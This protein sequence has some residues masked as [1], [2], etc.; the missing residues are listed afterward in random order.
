MNGQSNGESHSRKK[1]RDKFALKLSY[2]HLGTEHRD[3][4]WRSACGV[5]ETILAPPQNGIG[6][7]K[8]YIKFAQVHLKKTHWPV[9]KTVVRPFLH[10]LINSYDTFHQIIYFSWMCM[11]HSWK[12]S[13]SKS[14]TPKGRLSPFIWGKKRCI[15]SFTF[16]FVLVQFSS[17]HSLRGVRRFKTPMDCS[18]PGLPV[19]HQLPELTQ[20]QDHW[21]GDAIQPTHPLLSLAPPAINLTH[22]S[23]FSDESCLCIRLPKYL[24]EFQLQHQS[25]QWIFRTDFL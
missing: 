3:Q 4:S 6:L 8:M 11:H 20:T 13:F 24:L 19:H 23:V 7:M 17:A 16:P 25:F 1:I 10:L 18:T 21:V 14:V 22:I 9:K 12:K 2:K 5:H 15:L